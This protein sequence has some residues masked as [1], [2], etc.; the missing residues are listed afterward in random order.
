MLI[1]IIVLLTILLI[2]QSLYFLYYRRQIRNIGDQ[3]EFILDKNSLKFIQS[4]IRPK[5]IIRLIELCNKILER[6]RHIERNF[7]SRNE[8][9]NQT[10]VSLSHDIR[11]PLTS[12][13]GYLQLAAESDDTE[14]Q[15]KYIS[16]AAA[17]IKQINVLVDELFLYTKLKNP[18]YE[19]ELHSI[20]IS[21]DLKSF[22]FKFVEDFTEVGY[23]PVI[24][25][26]EQEIKISANKHALERVFENIIN[27]YFIHGAAGLLIK[28]SESENSV[29]YQ[30][31]NRIPDNASI[32]LT[33]IFSQFY[34]EDNARSEQSSG[35]GLAIVQALMHKMNGAVTADIINDE[36]IIELKFSKL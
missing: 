7:L 9:I 24:S 2:T 17:R 29:S 31:I 14:T 8:V 33:N 11:T 10:I 36:F 6:S 1:F 5:E 22:L 25:I 21:N 34:K 26:P 28:S 13:D 32:D 35:L 27:N 23:E 18:D 20:D 3:L 12:L 4:Q 19:L 16:M 15:T 30:F